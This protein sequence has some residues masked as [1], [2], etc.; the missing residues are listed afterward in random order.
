[1]T[2]EELAARMARAI[3]AQPAY[4]YHDYPERCARAA[5]AVVREEMAEHIKTLDPL[6]V[7][8]PDSLTIVDHEGFRAMLSASPLGEQ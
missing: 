5:L 6:F 8:T 2:R 3:G 7:Q 1:M 4:P